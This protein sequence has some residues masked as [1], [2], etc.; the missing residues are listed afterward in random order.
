MTV[1]RT[2]RLL[3]ATPETVFAA[4]QDPERLARWWGPD[5]FSNTFEVFEFKAGGR[6]QFVMHGPDGTNYPNQS[7]LVEIVPGALVRIRHLSQ[8]HFV[9]TISLS[10]TP[11]GTLVSWEQDFADAKVAE[12][13]RHIVEP[14]NEQN[15]DRLASELKA[16]T[17]K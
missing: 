7:E 9:L 11:N 14:A 5:G 4:I 2:T 12:S 8:P 15:L 3:E 13:I 6:W 1:F 16:G 17:Q 10:S